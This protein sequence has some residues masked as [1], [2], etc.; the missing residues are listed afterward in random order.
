M[1]PLIQPCAALYNVNT[2]TFR[3][4]LADLTVEHAGFRM[5]QGEGNSIAYLAGHLLYS[6]Y[7][8]LRTLRVA[9][10]NPW[11]ETFGSGTTPKDVSEYP[12]LEEMQGAWAAGSKSLGV[13]LAGLDEETWHSEPPNRYPTPDPT[14]RG[15]LFFMALHES[16]H[17]GQIGMLRAE[18]GYPAVQDVMAQHF[19]ANK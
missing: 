3:L 2:L 14:I 19:E 7:G 18:L 4:S 12:S 6:R 9:E 17:L 16:Y 13:A 1:H 5:K 10:E 15:A 8:L 11:K